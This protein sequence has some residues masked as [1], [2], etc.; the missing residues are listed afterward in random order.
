MEF[1]YIDTICDAYFNDRELY[2]YNIFES[3]VVGVKALQTEI[4]SIVQSLRLEDIDLY[5]ELQDCDKSEQQKIM[6]MLLDSYMI[7]T[8]PEVEES[9]SS[10]LIGGF[11]SLS[12]VPQIAVYLIGIAV[13]IVCFKGIAKLKNRIL[14]ALHDLTKLLASV[15]LK[16]TVGG[17]V[18]YLILVK[19]LD[20][21]ATKC[22]LGPRPEKE[23]SR[24]TSLAIKSEKPFTEKA[25]EQATCLIECYLNFTLEQLKVIAISYVNCLSMTGELP[26]DVSS[27]SILEIKPMGEQC[28]IF[29]QSLKQIEEQFQTVVNYIF[30][31]K[32]REKQDWNN[33]FNKAIIEALKLPIQR[34][35]SFQ[36]F[37]N[38]K[39]DPKKFDKKRRY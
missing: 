22:G 21:C 4:K 25:R 1:A 2:K 7:E 20:K 34:Q 36:R 39:Q 35:Q 32:A 38:K 18:K 15:I 8:Y 23:L 3:T 30:E 16:A 27:F 24:F 33:K 9:F 19:N 28:I 31:H 17:K 13:S 10:A 6:Y 11:T 14:N 37:D 12:F 26:K 29:Y 5:Y